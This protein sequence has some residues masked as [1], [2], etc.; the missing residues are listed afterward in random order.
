MS[1]VEN[2]DYENRNAR[3]QEPAYTTYSTLLCNGEKRLQ[4]QSYGSEERETKGS[5]SQTMQFTKQSAKQLVEI[6]NRE[7]KL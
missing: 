6:L 4:L 7:F 2:V 1:L 3:P 5:A